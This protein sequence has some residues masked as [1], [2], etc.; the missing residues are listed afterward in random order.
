[1]PST[2]GSFVC[3]LTVLV[4]LHI[5][6]ALLHKHT[7]EPNTQ[8]CLL[9]PTLGKMLLRSSA[10]HS[11]PLRAAL[12]ASRCAVAPGAG[13]P[14]RSSHASAL[15]VLHAGQHPCRVWPARRG[16]TC[17]SASPLLQPPRTPALPAPQARP[18]SGSAGGH[19]RSSMRPPGK[20]AIRGGGAGEVRQV[21]VPGCAVRGGSL[22]GVV[23]GR[24]R[25]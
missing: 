19:Q 18:V 23:A 16:T 17:S 2:L 11:T 8:T 15:H 22:P 6:P 12:A 1:M 24:K 10:H 21:Q 9:L 5:Q 14:C 4:C 3:A 13:W 25:A 7:P 20:H